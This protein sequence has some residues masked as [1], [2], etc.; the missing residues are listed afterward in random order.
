[1]PCICRYSFDLCGFESPEAAALD[2]ST[3]GSRPRCERKVTAVDS[4][5]SQ[6]EKK[7]KHHRRKRKCMQT[8]DH[9]H[10]LSELEEVCN[11]VMKHCFICD[12][13]RTLSRCGVVVPSRLC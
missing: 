12:K 13:L 8:R 3:R 10:F 5:L 7:Q 9:L 11:G 2:T 6:Q 1:M 4:Y